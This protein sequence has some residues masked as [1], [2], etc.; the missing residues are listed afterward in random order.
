MLG[1][2]NG[3]LARMKAMSGWL[4]SAGQLALF[5]QRVEEEMESLYALSKYELTTGCGTLF[6]HAGS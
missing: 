1:E 3:C 5:L 6:V 4:Q 2:L